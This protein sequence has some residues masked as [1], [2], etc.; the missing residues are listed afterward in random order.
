MMVSSVRDSM[1]LVL[2]CLA[3]SGCGQSNPPA[4]IVTGRVTYKGK[5][6]IG[7]GI[8]FYEPRIGFGLVANLDGDGRYVTPT[9][10]PV[11]AYQVSIT[12][13]QPGGPQIPDA[14]PPSPIPPAYV[15]EGYREGST[16]GLEARVSFKA[17]TFDYDISEAPAK[18][19]IPQGRVLVRIAPE[20]PPK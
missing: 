7:A 16:S 11:G 6:V 8:R 20:K 17:T 3:L 10:L 4:E 13:A 18:E 5:P 12:G 1:I 19:V 14:P 15:D 9:A 2:G